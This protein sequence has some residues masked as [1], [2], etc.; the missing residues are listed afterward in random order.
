[1][2]QLR[3]LVHWSSAYRTGRMPCRSLQDE[4]TAECTCSGD[5]R[6]RSEIYIVRRC[7]CR[8][9]WTLHLLLSTDSTALQGILDEI[10][11]GLRKR[12]GGQGSLDALHIGAETALSTPKITCPSPTV[13]L[14]QPVPVQ[15]CKSGLICSAV[16]P[17]V[18]TCSIVSSPL[19][20]LA[21]SL[22]GNRAARNL[23]LKTW[24]SWNDQFRTMDEYDTETW[25]R[26]WKFW[27][28]WVRFSLRIRPAAEKRAKESGFHLGTVFHGSST[29][30]T[31]SIGVSLVEQRPSV[32]GVWGDWS[33]VEMVQNRAE[34]QWV[35][36]TPQT[37]LTLRDPAERNRQKVAWAKQRAGC[38]MWYWFEER[39]LCRLLA[40]EGLL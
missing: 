20:S 9:F 2:V 17:V 35:S 3:T 33:L 19:F 10:W 23:A 25:R 37:L 11:G 14:C 8:D 6:G 34:S 24:R 32:M 18:P 12:Q 7:R 38:Q 40:P 16:I 4:Q 5:L 1:M 13:S 15:T 28:G 39:Y 22:R 36:N 26:S 27:N 29:C 30:S 31:L 21:E